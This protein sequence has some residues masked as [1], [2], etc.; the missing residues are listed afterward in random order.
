MATKKKDAKRPELPKKKAVLIEDITPDILLDLTP[1]Q[2]KEQLDLRHL[3]D[4]GR[5]K[6]QSQREPCPTQDF[7][8][9]LCYQ[10]GPNSWYHL[11][12]DCPHHDAP[13]TAYR[14]REQL[15]RY[16]E[17]L[18][19]VTPR[20][21]ARNK[22]AADAEAAAAAGQEEKA[23]DPLYD[24]SLYCREDHPRWLQ[25][26]RERAMREAAKAAGKIP[27]GTLSFDGVDR[28]G[29]DDPFLY[30]SYRPE[31]YNEFHRRF[32]QVYTFEGEE[33][34]P[35]PPPPDDL[36]EAAAPPRRRA[37]DGAARRRRGARAAAR[38][39]PRPPRPSR[40]RRP[41][42]RRPRPSRPRRRRPAPTSASSS[43]RRA[44][45]PARRARPGTPVTPV[46]ESCVPDPNFF[47]LEDGLD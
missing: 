2:L 40:P 18:A 4:Q 29:A 45:R 7:G 22:A 26:K 34:P 44:P 33:P 27:D 20:T 36:S 37:T 31:E 1:E 32:P 14:L 8:G 11:P 13:S 10:I 25:Y 21:E 35:P 12:E 5:R 23:Y 28:Y 41:R 17:L 3:D 39:R 9:C 16:D 38:A 6:P 19:V 24:W 47:D 15:E 46:P 42:P 43:R 30:G